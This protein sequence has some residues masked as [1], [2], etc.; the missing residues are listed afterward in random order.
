MKYLT[1]AILIIMF[2]QIAFYQG[3]T[4]NAKGENSIL[5]RG[6]SLTFDIGETDLSFSFNNLKTS[7]GKSFLP[8]YGFTIN[9]KNQTGI[10]NLFN[11]GDLVPE[12][13]ATAFIGLTCSNGIPKSF[14]KEYQKRINDYK[15]SKKISFE[16]TKSALTILVLKHTSDSNLISIRLH[17]LQLIENADILE[18][19]F[20]AIDLKKLNAQDSYAVGNIIKDK[21]ALFDSIKNAENSSEKGLRAMED[22]YNKT[23]YWQLTPYIFGGVNATEFKRF[24]AIDSSNFKNSFQDQYHR[25][26]QIGI[27][28][29]YQIGSLSLGLTYSYQKTNNFTL[30][31]KKEYNLKTQQQS[32]NQTLTEEKKITAY[33]GSYGE[34]E[35]NEIKVDLVYNINLLTTVKEEHYMLLNPYC[36]G[37]IFSR[38]QDLLPNSTNI[39]CGFYYFKSEGS[40]L[41]GLYVELPDIKNNYE[42]AKP[43]DEQNLRKPLERITFGIVTKFSIATALNTF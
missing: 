41:G 42:K 21:V 6:N 32:G 20:N 17:L 26:G 14:K 33:S 19:S 23:N 5:F 28:L 24:I 1:T 37:Q 16:E 7:L 4:K 22:T 34:L 43:I 27:G 8:I 15:S 11:R 10:G 9:T 13:K 18:N 35:L 30:L 29:N 31:N 12:A 40:F 3:I 25:G 36:R 39:G 38:K 2:S